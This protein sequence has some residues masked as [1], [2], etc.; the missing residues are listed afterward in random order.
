LFALVHAERRLGHQREAIVYLLEWG[1][2]V[3]VDLDTKAAKLPLRR[4]TAPG[5]E[6]RRQIAA[7]AASL[8]TPPALR[9]ML[10]QTQKRVAASLSDLRDRE[11]QI[12]SLIADGLS[13]KQIA[14]RM[15]TIGD[16]TS[17]AAIMQLQ[18]RLFAKLGVANKGE[19]AS[20]YTDQIWRERV[21]R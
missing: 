7:L 5:E 13:S 4:L 9:A 17:P 1:R 19:A 11:S 15:S 16:P 2:L 8:P 3:N 21:S 12:L 14:S 18:Y 6:L 10:E 20:W